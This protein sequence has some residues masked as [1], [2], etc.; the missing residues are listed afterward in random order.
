MTIL[1]RTLNVIVYFL[2]C[3]NKSFKLYCAVASK[4]APFYKAFLASMFYNKVMNCRLIMGHKD[5]NRDVLV[6]LENWSTMEPN[7]KLR[8]LHSNTVVIFH[9][10][11]C[12]I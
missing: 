4:S 6:T 11:L 7:D 5:P 9:F 2:V 3:L 10:W 8:F 1:I 12:I